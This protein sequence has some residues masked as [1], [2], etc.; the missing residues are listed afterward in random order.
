MQKWFISAHRKSYFWSGVD[1]D[2]QIMLNVLL[3][4]LLAFLENISPKVIKDCF[5]RIPIMPKECEVIQDR[6]I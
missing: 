4:Y 3:Q 5:N 2:V 1:S 6:F